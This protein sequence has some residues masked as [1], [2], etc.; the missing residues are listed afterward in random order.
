MP[1]L[2]IHEILR[3]PLSVVCGGMPQLIHRIPYSLAAL[4]FKPAVQRTDF[5]S[6][7]KHRNWIL[8]AGFVMRR[9]CQAV[10][11][12]DASRFSGAKSVPTAVP[13]AWPTNG[14]NFFC[15]DKEWGI[16]GLPL[17]LPSKW[18]MYLN[19]HPLSLLTITCAHRYSRTPHNAYP[20]VDGPHYA[21]REVMRYERSILV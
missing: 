15:L 13:H 17:S 3:Y 16:P 2:F 11:E 5:G 18:R 14:K 12:S 8:H 6:Q 21:L 1:I 10:G 4:Y 20:S 19:F 9:W 7:K